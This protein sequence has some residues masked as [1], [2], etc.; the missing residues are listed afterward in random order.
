MKRFIALI[1]ALFT[2]TSLSAQEKEFLAPF[3]ALDVDAQIQ[4]KLVKIKEHEAPYIIYDTKGAE[5][6]KFV[7]NI[8]NKTL[9][10]R[11]RHDSKRQSTTEVTIGFTSLTDISISKADA[12]V[13]GI[14]T[15]QLLDI[16]ISNDANFTAE[17]DVLDI[18]AHVSGKSRVEVWGYTRYHTAEVSSAHYN[19]H[20]LHS[21]STIVESSHNAIARVDAEERLEVKTLTGGKAY[22]LS[23][24]TLLRSRITAFGGEIKR[25]K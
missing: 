2:L 11:E 8:K 15:S 14:L 4:L 6:T 17:V 25:I 5:N 10:V 18:V 20:E 24:P 16:Y 7:F 23:Q 3:T 13:D 9:K 22:Y 21:V 1:A 19:A 12:K